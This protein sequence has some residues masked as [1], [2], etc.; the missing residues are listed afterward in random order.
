MPLS[1]THTVFNR[2]NKLPL[3]RQYSPSS[4]TA[5]MRNKG[6]KLKLSR[7]DKKKILRSFDF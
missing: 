1:F 5:K 6:D 7:V 4:A 2:N 3:C